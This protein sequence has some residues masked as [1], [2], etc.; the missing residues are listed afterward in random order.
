VLRN[1]WITVAMLAGFGIVL[2]VA[3]RLARNALELKDLSWPDGIA[4][5]FAQALALVPGVSRSGATIAGGLFLGYQ[6]EAATRYA[7]LLAIPA[8]FG[9]G[10]Y[11]LKDL[12]EDPTLVWG[13]TLAATV[14]AFVVGFAVIHWLLRY[15]SRHNFSIFVW[16][17]LALA[18]VVSALLLTGTLQAV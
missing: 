9:S 17:R 7:F 15:V 14:I 18:A 6:R 13:P 3:D 1:L 12:G 8:V 2:W 16:Y 10:L 11:K 4:L 5:G